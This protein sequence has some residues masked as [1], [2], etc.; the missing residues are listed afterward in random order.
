M[1]RF[2]ALL[3]GINVGGHVVKMDRL[4]ALFE[5]LEFSNVATFI[6][7]GNVIFDSSARSAARLE[8]KIEQ[9]LL[10]ALGYAVPTFVR[11]MTEL[12]RLAE[13]QPFPATLRAVPGS[14]LYVAFLKAAPPQEVWE[15]VE[16]LRSGKDDFHN[17]GR[18]VF[19][20]CRGKLS[21]S[22]LFKGDKFGKALAL[23]NTMRNATTVLKLAAEYA[24][25][26]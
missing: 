11:T 1:P 7:S 25:D 17:K 26:C 10:Q 2:V 3:R 18:E 8:S 20:Y 6:A 19:W 13:Y 15:K 5:E 21:E 24:S 23:P 22:P 9:H 12:A 16:A 4:R 14:S